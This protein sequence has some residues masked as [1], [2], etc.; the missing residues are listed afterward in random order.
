M[1]SVCTTP[2]ATIVVQQV[3]T[4]NFSNFSMIN[5]YFFAIGTGKY[6]V[7]EVKVCD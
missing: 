1:S 4:R 2:R 7:N 5:Y 3:R 6:C